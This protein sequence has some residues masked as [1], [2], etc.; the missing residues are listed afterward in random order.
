M[1]DST[2]LQNCTKLNKTKRLDKSG[3]APP[4]R[5]CLAIRG[6]CGA[7]REAARAL[8][9]SWDVTEY[10]CSVF[11]WG[12]LTY[13]DI[14]MSQSTGWQFYRLRPL[15]WSPAIVSLLLPFL[16][17]PLARHFSCP[18]SRLSHWATSDQ[19]RS[20][21]VKPGSFWLVTDCILR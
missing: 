5:A 7:A 9:Y 1:Q 3:S 15:T 14:G 20:S 18:R 13:S 17:F 4:P 16:F 6:H 8:K 2:S 21:V 12:F 11:H 10:K 19:E